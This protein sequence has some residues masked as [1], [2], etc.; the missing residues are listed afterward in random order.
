MF[1]FTRVSPAA[2]HPPCSLQGSSE[3]WNGRRSP[4]GV[5]VTRRYG[6]LK[7]IINQVSIQELGLLKYQAMNLINRR[8]I[9]DT[10]VIQDAKTKVLVSPSLILVLRCLQ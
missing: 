8:L 5:L 1:S 2:K 7:K 10:E 6:A 9:S 4:T 3:G